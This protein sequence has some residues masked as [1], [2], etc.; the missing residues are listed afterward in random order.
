MGPSL[1]RSPT[2]GSLILISSPVPIYIHSF[3]SVKEYQAQGNFDKFTRITLN[4]NIISNYYAVVSV[5][6]HLNLHDIPVNVPE[7]R[8]V[9]TLHSGTGQ[10]HPGHFMLIGSFLHTQNTAYRVV[11]TNL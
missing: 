4:H 5:H 9:I 11:F 3:L 2:S 7:L 1:Q 10:R 6:C 8:P